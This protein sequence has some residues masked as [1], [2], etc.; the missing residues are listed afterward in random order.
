MIELKV[1]NKNDPLKRRAEKQTEQEE[2]SPMAPPD[3]FAPPN[4]KAIPYEELHSFLQRFCDEH[5]SFIKE[6]DAF[7]DALIHIQQKGIDRKVDEKLRHF[8]EYFD[9]HIVTH[10]Q[11]EEK[12][13]FPLLHQRLIEKGEHGKGTV[14]VTAADM[15][16]DDH[17]KSLQLAAVVFNFFGL[18][19]R[20]PDPNSRLVV[21]DAAL[22][23]GKVL[24]ELLR[25]HIFREDNI[26]FSQA[27]Q[28]ITTAELDEMEKDLLKTELQ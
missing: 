7:E 24:I 22:E 27:H 16:E 14:P 25:L 11:R 5:K 9:Q 18:T 26:V 1:I 20:L 17:V 23:Q 12:L 28:L 2:F 6:L 4:L 21:L 15:L 10:G 8:F 3:A 19:M 13:L